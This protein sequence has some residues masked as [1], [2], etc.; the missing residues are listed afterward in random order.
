MIGHNN[1]TKR[2]SDSFLQKMFYGKL[3]K[4]FK[5]PFF[6]NLILY[7]W[8]KVITRVNDVGAYFIEYVMLFLA[9]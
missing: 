2:I 7:F 1:Y 6:H 5:K 4:T 9:K 8:K 3:I